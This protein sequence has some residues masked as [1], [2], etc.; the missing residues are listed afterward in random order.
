MASSLEHRLAIRS[1]T[2]Y[3]RRHHHH[4]A[5]RRCAVSSCASLVFPLQCQAVPRRPLLLLHPPANPADHATRVPLQSDSNLTA[6]PLDLSTASI[7]CV[8]YCSS[9]VLSPPLL[10][11]TPTETTSRSI[12]STPTV[13]DHDRDAEPV[14]CFSAD[15]WPFHRVPP[16]RNLPNPPLPRLY[17]CP[18]HSR[19]HSLCC[20]YCRLCPM[21]AHRNRPNLRRHRHRYS[22]LKSSHLYLAPFCVKG[23]GRGQCG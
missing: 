18:L 9:R 7:C 19:Q 3:H 16:P 11:P 14:C 20:C 4:L 22:P 6:I 13:I 12:S 23:Y 5:L 8:S 1:T 17:R 10:P 2:H 15:C 21:E